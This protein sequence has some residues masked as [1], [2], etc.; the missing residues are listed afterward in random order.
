MLDTNDVFNDAVK[1]SILHSEDELDSKVK[2]KMGSKIV[3]ILLISSVAVVGFN[4]YMPK[5]TLDTDLV[6]S[7][8]TPIEVKAEVSKKI[9]AEVKVKSEPVEVATVLDSEDEYLN[10]LKGIE[11][12]LTQEREVAT[13]DTE[14]QLELASAMSNLLDDDVVSKNSSYMDKLQK[15]IKVEVKKDIETTAVIA[16]NESK[17]KVLRKVIVK[18]GDTLQGLSDKFYGDAMN[19]KRI[20]AINDNLNS[21][22]IIYE[23][24]TILLPY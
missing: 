15:E 1:G 6:V 14:V 3:A 18:K 13:L 16:N 5:N 20:I 7:H 24:Q 23:G 17:E 8:E 4:F 19:Y 12:E 9:V 21:N 2:S 22:E 11:H 10:A